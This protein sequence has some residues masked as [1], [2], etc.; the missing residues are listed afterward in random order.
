MW[1]TEWSKP[2]IPFDIT[3]DLGAVYTQDRLEYVPQ[4]DAGNGT[5]YAGEVSYSL[6]GRSWSIPVPLRWE[7]DAR[8]KS[9]PLGNVQ[10]QFVRVHVT[11][12]A[13]RFG[14]GRELYV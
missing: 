14:S 3:A 7:R 10:A 1:H 11:A 5:F 9:F 4:S 12:A 6:D 8:S 13:G 2:T